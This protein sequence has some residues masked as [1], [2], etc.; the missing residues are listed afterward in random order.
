MYKILTEI[1]KNVNKLMR[2]RKIIVHP[3]IDP[4]LLLAFFLYN[5]R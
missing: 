3:Y 4:V 5:E 2:L 1:L